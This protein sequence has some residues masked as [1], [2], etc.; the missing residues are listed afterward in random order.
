MLN[1][2]WMGEPARGNAEDRLLCRCFRVS[3]AAV[4]R[5]IRERSLKTVEEVTACTNAAGGCSSCYDDI[6][7]IF[8]ETTGTKRIAAAPAMSDA[9][10]LRA[11]GGALERDVRRLYEIND[12]RLEITEV[13]GDQVFTRY[14]GRAA[15]GSLPSYLTLKWYLVRILSEACGQKMQQIELNALEPE[16]SAATQ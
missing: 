13:R 7:A 12:M 5:T 11:I 1:S 10:R 9:E 14:R 4:R 15:G 3:E 6:Q 8:D 16:R 2:R